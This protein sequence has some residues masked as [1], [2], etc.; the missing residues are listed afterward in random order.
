MATTTAPTTI[1]L[2]TLPT[3]ANLYASKTLHAHPKGTYHSANS[4]LNTHIS[5]IRTDITKLQVAAIVNAANESLLGGGGV[6]GAIHRAAGPKLLDEC[7]KLNGCDTGD[8]KI[9]DAYD[10][11][12]D[13]VI[14]AVGPVYWSAKRYG[15][16]KMLLQNCYWKSLELAVASGCTSIA[17]SALSTG[18]YGYPSFEAAF[19]ALEVVKQWL[20]HDEKK[21]AQLER[22]VFCSFMEKDEK[23]YEELAPYFFHPPVDG[24]GDGKAEGLVAVGQ[25][26]TREEVKEEKEDVKKQDEKD[27]KAEVH[28]G[29]E[30]GAIKDSRVSDLP[31][32]PKDQPKE[33]DQPDAKKQK[34]E[35]ETAE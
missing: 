20:D 4:T 3:L 7:E 15:K 14:H 23:V 17:F 22:I 13:K 31:D 35:P 8:A 1:S 19:A 30:D 16:H 9:T 32:V 6:D 18:V 26:T 2:T 11:P 25:N 33:E 27:V 5:L 24:G 29:V 21:A 34:I 28:D 12:C 10:L